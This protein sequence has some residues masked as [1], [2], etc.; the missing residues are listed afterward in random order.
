MTETDWEKV[1]LAWS[2][3]LAALLE[4]WVDQGNKTAAAALVLVEQENCAKAAALFEGVAV[5]LGPAR[6]GRQGIVVP[7]SE[8][9]RLIDDESA[10]TAQSWAGMPLVYVR[11][12]SCL[13]REVGFGP[14]R[15]LN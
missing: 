13:T 8:L 7:R 2:D 12:K 11:G 6:D 5:G 15:D 9:G 3:Y 14:R 4:Q 1:L 10:A